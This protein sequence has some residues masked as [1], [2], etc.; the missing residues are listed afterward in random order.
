[1]KIVEVGFRN[2]MPHIKKSTLA[3]CFK[4]GFPFGPFGIGAFTMKLKF[5]Y[6]DYSCAVV[7]NYQL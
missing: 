3:K 4:N 6:T 7:L 1:M 5:N 2:D